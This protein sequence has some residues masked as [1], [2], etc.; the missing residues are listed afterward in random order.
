[1]T[2]MWG[3][4]LRDRWGRGTRRDP[5]QARFLTLASLRWV[6]RHRAWTPWYL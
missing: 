6:L 2:S 5:E 4:P 3:S 1:M